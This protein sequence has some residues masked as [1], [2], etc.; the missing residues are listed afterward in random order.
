MK[1][2]FLFVLL[3]FM[4]LAGANAQCTPDTS[5]P[6][7]QFVIPLPETTDH[8]EY[9][10]HP[11]ACIDK[12]FNF[13]FTFSIPDTFNYSGFSVPLNYVQVATTGAIDNAPSWM[14]YDCN[15]PTCKFPKN[16]LGAVCLHGTPPS[17]AIIGDTIL[18]INAAIA[19]SLG[20]FNLKLPKDIPTIPGNY[21]LRTRP[22][23]NP[24]CTVATD[25]LAAVIYKVEAAPNPFS[26]LTTVKIEA[27]QSQTIDFQVFN[28]MGERVQNR[29]VALFEGENQVEMDAT[30]LPAGIYFYS[31][32]NGGFFWIGDGI[33]ERWVLV[34][35]FEKEGYEV[36]EKLFAECA[37]VF[38]ELVYAFN[39]HFFDPLGCRDSP[40][41]IRLEGNWLR[42]E[43]IGECEF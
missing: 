40:N 22:A 18:Q 42:V 5:I 15:P 32:G 24:L 10:I 16:T 2:L 29:R 38:C 35:I 4:G 7:D 14:S 1:R 6:P 8:P 37:A 26:F 33:F 23:G 12:P 30:E 25:E 41:T 13:T 21:I 3:I 19:T 20:T 34:N 28:F 27:L 39:V 11:A 36:V 31:I 17:N 9:G 43:G